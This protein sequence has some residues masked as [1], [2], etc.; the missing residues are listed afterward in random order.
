MKVSRDRRQPGPALAATIAV[1]L[2]AAV[3][4]GLATWHACVPAGGG[5][6]HIGL[7]LSLIQLDDG[8]PPGAFG[9]TAA[10]R[11][12]SVAVAASTP[13]L[14]AHM[15]LLAG[16]V[17]LFGAVRAVVTAAAGRL[18][19]FVPTPA[20]LPQVPEGRRIVDR[21]TRRP[22]SRLLQTRPY[23]RGPPV[24]LGAG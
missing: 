15:L 9:I 2:A 17:G 12:L 18:R 8:C 5:L 7:T 20:A 23:R 16:A 11:A 21:T 19:F 1:P 3:L 10:G 22:F 24:L 4:T 14:V 6:A 13:M